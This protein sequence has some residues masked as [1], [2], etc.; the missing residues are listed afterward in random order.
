MELGLV[1]LWDNILPEVEKYM[2][3]K[4]R[5]THHVS[6][7]I[8]SIVVKQILYH[9]NITDKR[10]NTSLLRIIFFEMIEPEYDFIHP[11]NID[12]V[13]LDKKLRLNWTHKQFSVPCHLGE[14]NR[15]LR[16]LNLQKYITNEFINLSNIRVV[17]WLGGDY[18]YQLDKIKDSIFYSYI[19]GDKDI[20][21]NSLHTPINNIIPTVF[22]LQ[23]RIDTIKYNPYM[24]L[25]LLHA[26]EH[27][28]LKNCDHNVCLMLKYGMKFAKCNINKNSFPYFSHYL[29]WSK[30][31]HKIRSIP[32]IIT[33]GYH[34][35]PKSP[36]PV[37]I[38]RCLV[39][40]FVLINSLTKHLRKCFSFKVYNNV[41]YSQYTT[42]GSLDHTIVNGRF[43]IEIY[44]NAT[45]LMLSLRKHN[46]LFF[47]T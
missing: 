10:L 30:F 34:K 1:L 40:D 47:T 38:I 24:V 11:L 35:I 46:G 31:I 16:I 28:I 41:R 25:Q 2:L 15:I 21:F 5:V 26:G 17:R 19:E 18:N 33:S 14:T 13:K 22:E 4:Y 3:N 29:E 9:W 43:T 45:P 39:K 6:C 37:V 23:K 12:L 7:K 36:A 27:Y 42:K 32:Y 20:Y 44:D 8:T